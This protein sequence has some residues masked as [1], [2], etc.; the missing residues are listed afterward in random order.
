[1][2]ICAYVPGLENVASLAA[3][4]KDKEVSYNRPPDPKTEDYKSSL[5]AFEL[6][7]AR[8]EQIH[9]CRIGRCLKYNKQGGLRCKRRA[10][11][12]TVEEDFVE[13]TGQWGSKRLY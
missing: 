9:T 1:M 8:M 13:S 11:F 3:V 6:R 10:P 7:L 2:N 12:P 4:P 5:E